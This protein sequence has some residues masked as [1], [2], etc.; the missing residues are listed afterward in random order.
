M[1]RTSTPRRTA[2]L[3][4]PL[5]D[6]LRSHIEAGGRPMGTR[7]AAAAARL[8]HDHEVQTPPATEQQ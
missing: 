4:A 8:T 3:S 2:S 6:R 1:K 5:V 7:P